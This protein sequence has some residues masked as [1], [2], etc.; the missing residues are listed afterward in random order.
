MT[1]KELYSKFLSSL[2]YVPY[3]I[4]EKQKIQCFLTYLP[5][6]FKEMTEYKNPKTLEE[7]MRKANF[8]YDQNTNK[9]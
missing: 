7:A 2:R 4:D 5:L 8:H 3:V 1:M 6:M 9:R